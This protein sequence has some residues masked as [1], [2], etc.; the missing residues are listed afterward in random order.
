VNIR[1]F[2]QILGNIYQV[3][4]HTGDWS[5]LDNELMAS[6]GEPEINLGGS[7]T[8]PPAFSLP[9]TYSRIKSGSPL[10]GRFDGDDYAD[11]EDRADVWAT[12]I[13]VRL[14]AD[15]DALRANTDGFT[16]ETVE[17]Y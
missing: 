4:I 5:Q 12:E 8:G 1:T 16:G 14:K 11:A 9:D 15:I 10:V 7:F 17:Q 6:Y 13:V 3:S 2:K